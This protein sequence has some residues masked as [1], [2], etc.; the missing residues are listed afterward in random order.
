MLPSKLQR[1]LMSEKRTHP[2]PGSHDLWSR[3][4]AR[5]EQPVQQPLHAR[6]N[7]D[8]GSPAGCGFELSRVRHVITLVAGTPVFETN[9]RLLALQA[10]DQLQKLEQADRVA[11]SAANVEGLS[12]ER[13]NVGLREKECVHEILDEEQV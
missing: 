4:A 2:S 12:G 3:E 8:L 9:G 11:K 7:V 1:G 13:V 10:P 5:F 6:V